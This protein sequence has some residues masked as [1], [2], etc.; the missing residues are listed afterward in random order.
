MQM[1]MAQSVVMV[2]DPLQAS[3]SIIYL[4]NV[5]PIRD[6][7][8]QVSDFNNPGR[9]MRV[10]RERLCW[11]YSMFLKSRIIRSLRNEPSMKGINYAL[12]KHEQL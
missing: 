1:E 7:R 5:A 2:T 11:K 10:A 4:G 6:E 3:E 8:A 12:V 9:Y